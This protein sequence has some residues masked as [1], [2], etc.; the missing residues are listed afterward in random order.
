MAGVLPLLI[1]QLSFLHICI[2]LAVAIPKTDPT[3]IQEAFVHVIHDM[4][5]A[6]KA[7]RSGVKVR[8][9]SILMRLN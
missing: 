2:C 4:E 3:Y 5:H 7:Y 9:V 1:M 8:L 6:K